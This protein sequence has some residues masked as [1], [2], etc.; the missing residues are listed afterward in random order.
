M[1]VDNIT[2][3]LV[4]AAVGT[5]TGLGGYFRSNK[6]DIQK[7]T[8]QSIRMESKIDNVALGVDAIRL[9]IKDHGRKIDTL[10]ERLIRCEESTRSGHKRL[11]EHLQLT[12]ERSV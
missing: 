3:G 1:V 7:D 6:K 12:E 2:V 11:D 9:D 4:C 10:N 5:V 8:T